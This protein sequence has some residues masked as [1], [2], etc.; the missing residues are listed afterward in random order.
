MLLNGEKEKTFKKSHRKSGGLKEKTESKFVKNIG[1]GEELESK[2][3]PSA[4][5][6]RFSPEESKKII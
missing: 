5:K 1:S 2:R 3:I 6:V 4:K